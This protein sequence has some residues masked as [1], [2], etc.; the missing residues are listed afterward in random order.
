[1]TAGPVLS[2]PT[3]KRRIREAD[4]IDAQ[5]CT[6]GFCRTYFEG[7]TFPAATRMRVV[8][9]PQAVAVA[10]DSTCFFHAQNQAEKVCESCG[11]FLCSVCAIPFDGATRCP[12]CIAAQTTKSPTVIPKRVLWDGLALT[13]AIVPLFVW[14]F[15]LVSAPLA[16]GLV[17]YGWN[18]PGSLV[19]G[20]SLW[21]LIV[22]GLFSLVQVCAWSYLGLKLL[23]R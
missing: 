4:W 17:I 3:C 8:P 2:C 7:L 11:R 5:S 22:A 20:R 12:N 19:R 13:V 18:K 23:T 16:L 9:K 1:M 15:T 14:P 6:C 10:D 21:R